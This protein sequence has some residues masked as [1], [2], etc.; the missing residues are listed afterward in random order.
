VLNVA[1]A[2]NDG[3][4]SGFGD[5]V[6]YPARFDS[7]IAVGATDWYDERA[8]FSSTGPDLEL[9]APGV[10]IYSTWPGGGYATWNGTS[11]ASPHVAGTA[12]LVIAA[13]IADSNGDGHVNDEVRQ[14]LVETALDLGAGGWDPLY[15]F[16]LVDALVAVEAANG[17]TPPPDPD[18]T[19]PV[20][21]DD[22]AL[23]TENMP[24]TIDVLAN[25][26]DADGDPLTVANVN[27]S[28]AGLV[29]VNADNTVTYTPEA[30]FTGTDSFTYTVNDGTVDGNTATVTITVNPAVNNPPVAVDDEAVTGENTPVVIDVLANDTDAD[31][32][33]LMVSDVFYSGT[34]S[35][36]VNADDTVTYTPAQGFSG[37]DSFS[38]TASDGLVNSNVATVIITVSTA[39]NLPPTAVD[40]NAST[41]MNTPV[42][43]NMVANDYDAD[44]I[45]EPNSVAI[46]S[47]PT[48]RGTVE[49]V[50]DGV[51][52]TPRKNF[53]GTDEFTYTVDD[54]LGA[55]SNV[56]TVTVSVV[57]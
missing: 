55:T 46:V 12:A 45:V 35:V 38:Y 24:V 57:R 40:D 30:S 21:V 13:G 28:G 18:N 27:Y 20:A 41:T 50:T 16:G 26:T 34:G 42:F 53:R 2:G 44:G 10:D 43:I 4:R 52:Y 29:V 11:M 1:A 14:V 51:I 3:R 25:D 54:D 19:P 31:G 22:E 17:G 8:S 33:P 36:T 37:T 49:I 5:S 48:R 56:A 23:T 39:G 9:A 6:D 32:D 15:G 7:V 47:S